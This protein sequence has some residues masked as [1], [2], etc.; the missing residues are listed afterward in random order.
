MRS[1]IL[2]GALA[3]APLAH[4]AAQSMR[5]FTTFRQL[6]GESRLSAKLDF[7]AG[8]LRI[9]SGR[10]DELYRMTLAYDADRFAPLSRYDAAAGAVHLGVETVGGAGLRVVS[11]EQIKQL[12]A[13]ELSPRTDLTLDLTLGAAEGNIELG[14]LRVSRL[15]LQTG[16]SRTAVHFSRPNG[17]RCSSAAFGAGAAELVVTGLANSRCDRVSL[18]GGVGRATLDFTGEL[19]AT[20]Q[21]DITMAIGE[22]ALRLPRGVPVRIRTDRLLSSFKPSGLERQG[23]AWITPG[24]N[25]AARHLDV[26]LRTAVGGITLEWV[27]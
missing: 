14:G 20:Q 2:A 22:L 11:G 10:S 15:A 4:A 19:T 24:F 23:D 27:P 21:A 26:T 7:A 3:A 6:H 17:V 16:A 18:E 25:P 8:E 9:V 12:A 13:V 5:P 1:I